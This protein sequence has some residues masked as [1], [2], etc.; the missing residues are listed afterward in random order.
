LL[1]QSRPLHH[2]ASGANGVSR[3][4]PAFSRVPRGDVLPCDEKFLARAL[5]HAAGDPSPGPCRPRSQKSAQHGSTMDG[6]AGA[7][8]ETREDELRRLVDEQMALRRV[9]TLVASR[10]S[11]EDIVAAVTSE[12]ARLFGAHRANTMRWDGET[13][14]VI[15]DW[16]LEEGVTTQRGRLYAFGGD[17]VTARVVNS[18]APA[19]IDAA[20]DLDTDFGRARWDELGL[21]ASIGAPVIVNGSIWGVITASRTTPDD[22]FPIGA[23][24]RLAD[25]ATL[26]AQAI[27]NS[28]ARRELAAMVEEQAALRRVAT[29][30]AGGRPQPEVLEAVAREAGHVFDAQLV[31]LVRWDGIQDE[32]VVLGGWSD[33]SEVAPE[34]ETLY[35]PAPG[36]ATLTVLETGVP[37][38]GDEPSRELGDRCAI[39]APVIVDAEL[40][41]ALTAFRPCG[42][43]FPPPSET[44]LRGFSDLVAQG[45]ANERAHEEMRDSRA[46]IVQ[47]ADEA[48]AKLERNLHDGAQQQLAAVS[49]RINLTLRALPDDA[50][51]ARDMLEQARNLLTEA[52]AELRELAR[53]LHPAILTERGLD[54]ALQVLARRSSVPV[55]VENDLEERLPPPV[56]AGL[57]YVVA[58]SLTNIAKYAN[59]STAEVRVTLREDTAC[60][61]VVDDGVG[62]ADASRGS[63]LLGLADRV[64]TLDGRFGVESQRRV[65]TRVWA[66]IPLDRL[67]G[68]QT[69]LM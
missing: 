33:G 46:R 20:G 4:E 47:A 39:S 62:G 27:A 43:A 58:E 50:E 12:I 48:R 15:G 49:Q 25:F 51:A 13:I 9:A 64:E 6:M 57:Y 8:R 26:V 10:A 37:F 40:I 59:A 22:P 53:G 5:L 38:R 55:I 11:E 23:E 30:V 17:T 66:E 52:H 18:G 56:E 65:G 36:S 54:S 7:L 1:I 68:R 14:R 34:P 2:N 32:V 19:R 45:I 35:H 61:E 3:G 69:Q 24:Q 63:G 44:H 16:T 67:R 29:L 28:E 21:E 42:D 41:G 60:V 31:M